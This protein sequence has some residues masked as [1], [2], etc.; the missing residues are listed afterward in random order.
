MVTVVAF[1]R[2]TGLLGQSV[3]Q[4]VSVPSDVFRNVFCSIWSANTN[5]LSDVFVGVAECKG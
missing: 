3:N 4:S 5:R 1:G 2:E